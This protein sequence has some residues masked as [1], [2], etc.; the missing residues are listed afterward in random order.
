MISAKNND[1]WVYPTSLGCTYKGK[2]E[3]ALVKSSAYV[4]EWSSGTLP[5]SSY[6]HSVCWSPELNLFCAIASHSSFAA[7]S[8]DGINWT[9]RTLP[10]SLT[11]ISV[12]WSPE[13]HLFCAVANGS[14]S[15][16]ISPDGINW[17]Q[18]T[19]PSSLD[20]V[21]VCWSPE[22][23]LF[24]TVTDDSSIAATSPDGITWTQRTLPES[25]YW[26]SVCWSPE[27]GSFC[28]VAYSSATSAIS[29]PLAL[30]SSTSKKALK[31]G[32]Y[33]VHKDLWSNNAGTWSKWASTDGSWWVSRGW[34]LKASPVSIGK[35]SVCWSPELNLFCAVTTGVKSS[36]VSPN[37]TDFYTSEDQHI[38]TWQAVCWSP[39]LRL[40]VRVGYEDSDSIA[41]TSKDG[42]TW[43][44]S[45]LS[46]SG[47]L[48]KSVCWAPG[49]SKFCAVA[50]GT[51]AVISNDGITWTAV[52]VPNGA[53]SSVCY[54]PELKWLCAV[55]SSPS[56]IAITSNDGG[57]TW[58][59]RTL[60]ASAYWISVC[61]SPELNLFCAIAANSSIAATSYDGITWTQRALPA[62]RGWSSIAWS[63]ELGLFCAIPNNTNAIAISKDGIT[64]TNQAIVASATNVNSICWSPELGKFCAVTT[65]SG[66]FVTSYALPHDKLDV[67]LTL[68]AN[69]GTIVGGVSSFTVKQGESVTLPD[70]T[71]PTGY[72]F[73]GW[74]V[75]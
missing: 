54:S 7:T 46:Q 45:N 9:Q 66:Y 38:A 51:T 64:W 12:C 32:D 69:G 59:S 28:I 58:A 14:S 73:E 26:R 27:I 18:R 37:G 34:S 63:P 29:K 61:W 39:E 44:I 43:T 57:T 72:T 36:I 5:I 16:A 2:P 40:F 30:P 70:V 21:S 53:W 41:S 42:L 67:T 68:D 55:S 75:Q 11:C 31:S 8:P 48:L 71:P 24:C 10:A 22:L 4:N 13:L 3:L 56:N 23:H 19:L 47:L 65:N 15:A 74:E 6:W 60:P 17:T 33:V 20:W 62:V 1:S 49:W 50:T 52:T 25:L 35:L